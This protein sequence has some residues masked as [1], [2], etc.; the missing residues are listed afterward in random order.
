MM[1]NQFNT[2]N[3]PN[4]QH[5]IHQATAANVLNN[6]INAQQS[7]QVHQQ[8]AVTAGSLYSDPRQLH[9]AAHV[10]PLEKNYF[11]GPSAAMPGT[12]TR[13]YNNSTAFPATTALSNAQPIAANLNGNHHHQNTILIT[14]NFAQ[15][16][17]LQPTTDVQQRNTAIN[18][19]SIRIIPST[20]VHGGNQ[21][22]TVATTP[23]IASLY[24]S[25][26]NQPTSQHVFSL[27]NNKTLQHLFPQHLLQQH[28]YQPAA[29]STEL[30]QQFGGPTHN[31]AT[32]PPS[33]ASL[34]HQQHQQHLQQNSNA[35]T[36]QLPPQY[37]IASENAGISQQI[38]SN[39]KH[40]QS[41]NSSNS[42]ANASSSPPS[43]IAGNSPPNGST[44]VLDRINICINN[45]Y[46]D[47][48]STTTSCSN[49]L[50]STPAQQ[51]SPIIPAIQH[52]AIIETGPPLTMPA[53]YESN[54]LV[55]DEPDSTTT[56]TTPHTPPTTPENTPSS[57]GG[58][59]AN[60]AGISTTTA[61]YGSDGG[62]GIGSPTTSSQ[63]E[64]SI[65]FT[66]T[67]TKSNFANVA[68]DIE[69]AAE[70]ELKTATNSY[71][72]STTTPLTPPSPEPPLAVNL[73]QQESQNSPTL[74]TKQQQQQEKQINPSL[75][76]NGEDVFIKRQDERFYLGTIIDAINERYLVQF[77]DR[78]EQWCIPEEM[79]K[80]GSSTSSSTP[81]KNCALSSTAASPV[82]DM[83]D[84]P[85]CVACKRL[86]PESKVETC[87]RCGRGYHRKCTVETAVGTNIWLCKRCA[88]PM[89]LNA[90][91]SKIGN[92]EICY[93]QLSYDVSS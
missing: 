81:T 45:L 58:T 15:Q 19:S 64:R 61:I 16:A 54:T 79:R 35:A 84:Q 78:S 29:G 49:S 31:F 33:A 28:S 92:E 36:I 76:A 59:A 6:Y 41:L 30:M 60:H 48:S 5:G 56:A 40:I 1:N 34:N 12:Q 20:T 23:A 63:P 68:K 21:M 86:E 66:A 70:Q 26:Q 51:P 83:S 18:A 7:P 38:N 71:N 11:T 4:H 42:N 2:S 13:F 17:Q 73:Q 75:F 43:F 24:H 9:L 87:E 93:S 22:A 47:T 37:F 10:N 57:L 53:E 46:T 72:K 91:K 27:N 62:G 88:K 52:K 74:Q 8:L 44:V 82:K 14:N 77:D 80:L 39:A 55:I 25:H 89:K 50:S 32:S 85:M 67:S 69:D 3:L 90:L 65:S